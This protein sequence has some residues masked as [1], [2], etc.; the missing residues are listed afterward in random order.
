MCADGCGAHAGRSRSGELVGGGEKGNG[1]DNEAA[2]GFCEVELRGLEMGD[3]GR[4]CV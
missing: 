1:M 4:S 3:E 2:L